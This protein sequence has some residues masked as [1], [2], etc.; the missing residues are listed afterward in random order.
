MFK[1]YL[2][3]GISVDDRRV[4]FNGRRKQVG[5]TVFLEPFVFFYVLNAGS[6][7]RVDLQHL[8]EQADHRLVQVLGYRKDA[9]LDLAEQRRDMFVVK[10]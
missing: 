4:L 3:Y 5:G 2:V 6:L 10:R 7:H 1:S 8:A 9:R